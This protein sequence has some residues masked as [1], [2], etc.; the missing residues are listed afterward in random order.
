MGPERFGPMPLTPSPHTRPPTTRPQK[1][2]RPNPPTG[3]MR[4]GWVETRTPP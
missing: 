3:G 4:M 2:R 1:T